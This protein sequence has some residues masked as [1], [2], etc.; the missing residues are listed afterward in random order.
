MSDDGG[1]GVSGGV[2]AV[3]CVALPRVGERFVV[4]VGGVGVGRVGDFGA[5]GG[6]ATY[7]AVPFED[8]FGGDVGG[9]VEEGGVVEDGL[10]VFR[11]LCYCKTN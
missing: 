8:F 4:V 10:E 1:S 3:G 2:G 6:R 11:Y 5:L 9:V 7:V